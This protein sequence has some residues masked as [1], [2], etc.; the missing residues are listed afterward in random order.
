MNIASGNGTLTLWDQDGEM[1]IYNAVQ[2][3]IH[4]PSEHTFNGEHRDL[5]LHLVH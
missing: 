2:M 4:A 5:E 3:H 1:R